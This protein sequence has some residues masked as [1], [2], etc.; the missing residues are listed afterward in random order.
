MSA[1]S[2]T[3]RTLSSH[4]ALAG[5]GQEIGA[6]VARK[7]DAHLDQVRIPGIATDVEVVVAEFFPG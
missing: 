6:L 5:A 1:C 4:A 7:A 2:S 3:K